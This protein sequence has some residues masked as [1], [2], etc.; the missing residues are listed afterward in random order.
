MTNQE[1]KEA[2]VRLENF[3]AQIH[4]CV[5]YEIDFIQRLGNRREL[6]EYRDR[7]LDKI[8]DERRLLGYL[9]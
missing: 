3:Y 4:L 1:R 2:I 7:I 8:N 5:V 6:E 9:S